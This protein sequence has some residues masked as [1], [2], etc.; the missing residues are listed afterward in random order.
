MS[1]RVILIIVFLGSG[2]MTQSQDL[3]SI[4]ARSIAASVH[5]DSVMIMATRQG[6]DVEDFMLLVKN[7]ESLHHAFH[8][9]R[10]VSCHF[11]SEMQFRNKK[12][13]VK[14]EMVGTYLQQY[15]GQCRSLIEDEE[16]DSGNYF[17]GR[18]KK[19]RYYTA[20][21]YDRVF[22]THGV[23][24]DLTVT[25]SDN[26][27]SGDAIDG[28]MEELKKL[29]FSPGSKADVPFIGNKTELFSEEMWKYYD[30]SIK[31][32]T[33]GGMPVYIFD[34]SVKNEFIDK[35]NKTVFKTLTT[36]FAKSDFQVL[37]RT[38]RLAYSTL[39]Y[40]FDV[41]MHIDLV[42]IEGAYYPSY[43]KYSGTW[44]IPTKKRESG[45][46]TIDFDT[47]EKEY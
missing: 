11:E 18:K 2:I 1:V 21:L 45:F 25:T 32:D 40:M 20:K 37:S 14:A 27:E 43:V 28:H 4:L 12:N 31:S 29:I 30:F 36:Y 38:Y 7:D 33:F 42:R 15:D 17:K 41:T 47:F 46:F 6:F 24:C 3:D 5:L 10:R 23:V 13:Q 44:N 39:I 8:N 9:L 19:L 34:A 16:I 35:E 26:P 22:I